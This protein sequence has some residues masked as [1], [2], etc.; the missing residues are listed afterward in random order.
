MWLALRWRF[1]E[2]NEVEHGPVNDVAERHEHPAQFP[3]LGSERIADA[4]VIYGT[5]GNFCESQSLI[6]ANRAFH[7]FSTNI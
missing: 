4:R 3:C 7:V 5:I 1:H 6:E 2:L